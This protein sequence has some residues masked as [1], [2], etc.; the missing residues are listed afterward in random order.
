MEGEI[1]KAIN[2]IKQWTRP[3]YYYNYH[4]LTNEQLGHYMSS[5]INFLSTVMLTSVVFITS[6]NY[7][8]ESFKEVAEAFSK[9][10]IIAPVIS[11]FIFESLL[12][13]FLDRKYIKKIRQPYNGEYDE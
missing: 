7:D 10:S 8:I 13:R 1:M 9:T 2:K 4:A 3:K 6:Y 5:G 12:N 11:V